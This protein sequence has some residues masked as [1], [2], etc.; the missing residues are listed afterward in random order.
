MSGS[1]GSVEGTTAPLVQRMALPRQLLPSQ[2][3]PP[4]LLVP[5]APQLLQ[6]L[7]TPLRL[8]Y[9]MSSTLPPR[10]KAAAAQKAVADREVEFVLSW[11]GVAHG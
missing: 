2:L 8:Q 9:E 1:G 4:K 7:M 6:W 5:L 10:Q 11:F 3:L